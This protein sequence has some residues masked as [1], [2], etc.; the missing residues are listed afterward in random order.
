MSYT[1]LRRELGGILTEAVGKSQR[2]QTN[3]ERSSSTSLA[4]PSLLAVV[5]G[6][7]DIDGT[8]GPIKKDKALHL[9]FPLPRSH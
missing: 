2:T 6:W 1:Q 7:T 5:P 8:T 9:Q 4:P 3:N